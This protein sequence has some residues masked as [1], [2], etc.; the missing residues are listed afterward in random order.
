MLTNRSGLNFTFCESLK[1]RYSLTRKAIYTYLSCGI[2]LLLFLT[3]TNDVSAQLKIG[4]DPTTIDDGSILELESTD[5]AFIPPR[6]TTEE[7]DQIPTP[8]TGAIIYNTTE[9]CL[10]VMIG[11]CIPVF[12]KN[13]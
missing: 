2:V 1:Y 9:E 7:R 5:K 6:M 8:L 10:Q 4:G 12:R 11:G 3:L 13:G